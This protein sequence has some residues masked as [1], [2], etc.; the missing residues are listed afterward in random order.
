MIEAESIR[1]VAEEAL[2]DTSLY[3]VDITVSPGNDIVI[4]LDSDTDI[5]IDRCAALSRAVE[6]ALDR[7]KEDFSLEVGSAGLTSPL[8]H[9]R[10]FGKY[11]GED[12]EVLTADGRKLHGVLENAQ[13]QDG[14]IIFDLRM[15]RKVKPEGAKRPVTEEFTQSLSL[16]GCKYIKPDLRF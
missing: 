3:I 1:T 14:D 8:R 7:D 10:Q 12:M 9:I 2:Q 4:E 16:S 15:T 6:A 13:A 11:R 5:D